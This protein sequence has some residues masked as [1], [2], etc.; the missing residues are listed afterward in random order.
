MT[1]LWTEGI[2]RFPARYVSP[3]SPHAVSRTSR[4]RTFRGTI[5]DKL[6]PLC[7]QMSMKLCVR[8]SAGPVEDP[9][10]PIPASAGQIRG[11]EVTARRAVVAY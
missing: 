10:T 4:K 5:S 7:K 11:T 9:V 8:P 1:V 6:T 2:M 3:E